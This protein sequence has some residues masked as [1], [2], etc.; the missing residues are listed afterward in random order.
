MKKGIVGYID[1]FKKG[2]PQPFE[3]FKHDGSRTPESEMNL[4][5]IQGQSS[6]KKLERKPEKFSRKLLEEIG[7]S[8]KAIEKIR[9][10]KV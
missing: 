6:K 2:G 5:S 9:K 8:R 7:V 4:D 10:T 1:P 3:R